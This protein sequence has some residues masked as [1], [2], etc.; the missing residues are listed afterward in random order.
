M[1]QNL[2]QDITLPMKYIKEG[3]NPNAYNLF[4]KVGYDPTDTLMLGRLPS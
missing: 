1:A 3:F 2:P 4:I